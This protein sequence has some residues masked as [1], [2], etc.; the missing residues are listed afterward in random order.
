MERK[1]GQGSDPLNSSLLVD[2]MPVMAS[3][4]CGKNINKKKGLGNVHLAFSSTFL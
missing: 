2:N 1:G 4:Y 3:F